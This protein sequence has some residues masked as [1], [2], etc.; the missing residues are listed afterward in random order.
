M[1]RL[2]SINRLLSIS[3][4]YR[5]IGLAILQKE[6]NHL[7]VTFV[8]SDHQGSPTSLVLIVDNGAMINQE[9]SAV[10]V[11]VV[12]GIKENR[13]LSLMADE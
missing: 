9:L 2:S 7:S 1:T 5:C 11:V 10:D 4:R 8:S 13:L 6:V 3:I 12:T